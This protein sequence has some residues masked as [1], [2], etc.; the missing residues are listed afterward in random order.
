MVVGGM[1]CRGKEGQSRRAIWTSPFSL[2]IYIVVSRLL[3]SLIRGEYTIIIRGRE[4][5]QGRTQNIPGLEER[6]F[7]VERGRGK[8]LGGPIFP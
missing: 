7:Q 2:S 3:I 4:E 8:V 1:Q 6:D 5:D